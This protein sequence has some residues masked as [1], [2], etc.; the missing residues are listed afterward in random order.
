MKWPC[1]SIFS[2]VLLFL[3]FQAKSQVAFKTIVPQHPFAPGESF[4][5]Q[6][7][8]ENADNI[9]NFSPPQ[10]QGFRVVAGP[11][12]YSGTHSSSRKNLV[13]TLAAI[14][15]GKY[16]ING[17]SCVINGKH[18][19]S[20]DVF[21]TVLARPSQGESSYF[22][23]QGEDALQKIRENLF[24][25]MDIDKQNCFIGEPLVA[26]FKLYSRLQ[27][28][29]NVVKNPGFYGFSV[30]DMVNLNDKSETE[31]K[32]N[33]HWYDV[34]TVR[35]VQLYPLQAGTFTI[36]PMELA[37][38]IEFSR[39]E[40]TKTGEAEITEKM[41]NNDP[42][43][44][45]NT[46]EKYSMNLKTTPSVIN[47][48]PLPV[49]N[50]TDT[51]SGAVGS[52]TIDVSLAK[53]SVLKNNEDSMV[54]EINGAGNF[55]RVSAPVI[56]WPREIEAFEPTVEDT[57]D[58]QRV[59]LTG[60]R[61]LK[62][63]FFSSKAGTYIIPPIS[64]TFFDLK[65]KSYK[66]V[67]SKPLTIY[68]GEKGKNEKPVAVVP[69]LNAGN[70]SIWWVIAAVLIIALSGSWFAAVKLRNS[71]RKKE[72]DSLKLT[73]GI[74]S[75][76]QILN[77]AR[78]ALTKENKFFYQELNDAMWHYFRDRIPSHRLL[79]KTEL[80]N[81]LTLKNVD[82]RIIN[83]LAQLLHEFETGIYANAGMEANKSASLENA[84]KILNRVEHFLA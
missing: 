1:R 75:I 23:K 54:I 55:Q 84:E 10:F 74:V 67:S 68:V 66:T 3:L 19:K 56:E 16:K 28:K 57:L 7:V 77:P 31:E 11:N 21:V 27:S 62:Y 13:F 2:I 78:M 17:A 30:Y 45:A 81:L 29:S 36:D 18:Q 8:I 32:L 44:G 40:N 53:D 79:N 46:S 33:G 47:V 22:L 82:P 70:R 14:H 9:A 60:S 42:A 76:D 49:K 35:K 51:F 63:I 59:P 83:E 4:Q 37:N 72:L 20:N 50:M 15:E 12:V 38:E 61:R 52:F 65:S 34:H 43:S 26:T 24:L 39:N 5:V 64:F 48:K 41:Y 25:K 58:K 69:K 73:A 6:Y 71:K 80:T